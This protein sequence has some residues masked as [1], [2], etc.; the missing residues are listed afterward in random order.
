MIQFI[1]GVFSFMKHDD[2]PYRSDHKP[3]SSTMQFTGTDCNVQIINDMPSGGKKDWAK[4]W[5]PTVSADSDAL[6]FL[7]GQQCET[8]AEMR[9]SGPFI[10]IFARP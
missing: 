8:Y 4:G 3:V 10:H 6:H 1:G 9:R 7:N 2:F 5:K